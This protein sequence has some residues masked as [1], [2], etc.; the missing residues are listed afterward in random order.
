M[1]LTT[2]ST[3]ERALHEAKAAKSKSQKDDMQPVARASADDY[4]AIVRYGVFRKLEHSAKPGKEWSI[5][6]L[7]NT[8]TGIKIVPSKCLRVNV[9]NV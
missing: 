8:K 5:R 4:C 6:L 3:C 7:W 9:L 2:T 1:C